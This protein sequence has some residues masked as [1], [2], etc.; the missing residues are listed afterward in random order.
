MGLV[1]LLFSRM[2]FWYTFFRTLMAVA[3]A[4]VP[5]SHNVATKTTIITKR[6]YREFVAKG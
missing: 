1:E 5:H 4:Q 6:L 3:K 2:H